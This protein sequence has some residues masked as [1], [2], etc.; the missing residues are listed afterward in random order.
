ME[1]RKF[2]VI[3]PIILFSYFL[4][5]LDNSVVFTST[6][7]IAQNLNMSMQ[8]VAW[9]SNIYS[10]FF[11]SV[12]MLGGRLGDLYGRKKIF[13]VALSIFTIFSLLVGLA[14]SS[15]IIIVMRAFQGLGAAL[16]APTSLSLLMENFKGEQRVKAI[17]YYGIN[18]GLGASFGLIVGGLVTTFY[19]WRLGFLVNVPIGILMIGLTIL[20][21]PNQSPTKHFHL[22]ILGSIISVLMILALVN[23]INGIGNHILFI[24]IF[25][26]LL[27]LFIILESKIKNPMLPLEVFKDRERASDY[28][29]RFFFFG[30]MF[31]FF[32]L[33]PQAMQ[34]YYGFT[35]LMCAFG[36]M[37]Q[38][39]SQFIFGF[40][41][42]KVTKC[43]KN[44]SLLLFGVTVSTIGLI[45]AA[46]LGLKHG[47]FIS[48]VIPMIIIGIGQ[49]FCLGP[50]T[51]SGVAN[52]SE[53]LSGSASGAV[54]VFPQLGS[55]ILIAVIVSVTANV[56]NVEMAYHYQNL[57]EVLFMIIALL[58]VI[59]IKLAHRR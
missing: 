14:Q 25:I 15:F 13:L 30:A 51:I 10:L 9:I 3:L 22:D 27:L 18:A 24:G 6:V 19:S 28:I 26:V 56:V 44:E 59:N 8:S 45:L 20:F 29:A 16:L 37:P 34:R 54:N 32:F 53:D 5:L 17:S 11:G 31:A 43:F 52:I 49:G 41:Q 40:V 33:C 7:K 12:L 57:I 42:S 47:Y 1:K 50:L 46:V 48:M 55:S 35:P 38:T 23:G 36:F 2:R 58:M 21:I 4:I 39:V